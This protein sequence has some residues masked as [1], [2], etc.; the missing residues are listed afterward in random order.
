MLPDSMSS[1]WPSCLTR[2]ETWTPSGLDSLLSSTPREPWGSTTGVEPRSTSMPPSGRVMAVMSMNSLSSATSMSLRSRRSFATVTPASP[3]TICWLMVAIC[4]SRSLARKTSDSSCRSTRSRSSSM[5]WRIRR[6]EEA[7][8]SP[9]WTTSDRAP[10]APGEFASSLHE[11]KNLL[12]SLERSA[13][14]SSL[15]MDS[16]LEKS[17]SE[18]CAAASRL[19][20]DQSLAWIASSTCLRMPSTKTPRPVKTSP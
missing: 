10:A 13:S 16:T 14:E 19:M 20:P 6:M 5:S 11:L 1:R 17:W 2:T 7:R 3:V 4:P 9:C 12:S 15:S 18:V 8:V